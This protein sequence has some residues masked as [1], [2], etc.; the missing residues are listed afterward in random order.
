M[1]QV[2]QALKL[3]GKTEDIWCEHYISVYNHTASILHLEHKEIIVFLTTG[4][5]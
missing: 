2:P 4:I 1:G 3:S 5:E